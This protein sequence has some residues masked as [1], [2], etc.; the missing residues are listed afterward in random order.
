MHQWRPIHSPRGK[1]DSVGGQFRS[2]VEVDGALG[3]SSDHR[4]VLELDSAV[5][6]Q[7]AGSDLCMEPALRSIP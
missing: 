3:E 6:D 1:D 2:I 5:E 4:S 7:L